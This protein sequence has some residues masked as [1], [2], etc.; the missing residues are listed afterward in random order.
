[1]QS[2]SLINSPER[3]TEIEK[4]VAA[5]RQAIAEACRAA[6]R[7]PSDVRLI[8][9][10]KTFPA[11]DAASLVRLG[12]T[13]IGENREQDAAPKASE[14]A[15]SQVDAEW[16]FVGQLQR[17]KANSVASFAHWVHSVDRVKL[18]NALSKAALSHGKELNVLLQVNL[19]GEPSR[20]GVELSDLSALAEG[21][22]ASEALRLRGVMGIAPIDWQPAKAFDLVAQCSQTVQTVER[23]AT[24]ISAG[25]SGDYREAIASGATMIRLGAKLL[26][27]RRV[28][29]GGHPDQQ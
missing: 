6:G 15:A 8:G 10:T 11:V 17:N 20:G 3:D 2:P 22:A 16:H 18:V 19:D 28:D 24:E 5:A 7:S 12:V 4:N 23:A 21:V 13:D 14:L 25:M 1:M 9:I 26:G 27:S 29:T